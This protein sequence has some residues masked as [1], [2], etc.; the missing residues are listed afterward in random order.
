MNAIGMRPVTRSLEGWARSR[1]YGP[2]GEHRP[3]MMGWTEEQLHASVAALRPW[4]TATTKNMSGRMEV[5]VASVA[6]DIVVD[7]L[8][9]GRG[10]RY[11]RAKSPY[12]LPG[13]Y[14]S[15]DPLF[16]WHFVTRAIDALC[17][18]GLIIHERGT[19]R[20]NCAGQQSVAKSTA[21][22]TALLRP[23]INVLEP[24]GV[25][26]PDEVIV[27]RDRSDKQPI[28]YDD[29][30]KTRKM[31]DEVHRIN[32]ALG[33][34]EVRHHGHKVVISKGRRIFSGS[35]DLGGRFYLVGRSIQGMSSRT[36][37]ELTFVV[38][39]ASHPAVEVDYHT[40]HPVLAYKQSGG[41]APRGDLYAI[42]GFDRKLVKLALNIL[43]NAKTRKSAKLALLGE[44]RADDSREKVG[45]GS[46]AFD[47]DLE[48]VDRVLD[49]VVRKHP[50]L[51]TAFGSD[52]GA[53]LQRI[54]SDMAMTVL[55]RM[56]E[57]TGRCPIPIHDSFVV[58]EPDVFV[59]R[60]TMREVAHERGLRLKLR[61][62]KAV[63]TT[64]DDLRAHKSP[65]VSSRVPSVYNG[66]AD[67]ADTCCTPQSPPPLEVTTPCL[68]KQASESPA[69]G[70][71]RFPGEQQ[72]GP[73]RNRQRVPKAL[74]SQQLRSRRWLLG[75][76]NSAHGPPQVGRCRVHRAG[77]ATHERT[78]SPRPFR[79]APSISQK[80]VAVESGK[81]ESVHGL[82]HPR[83]LS[84]LSSIRKVETRDD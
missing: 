20:R 9:G 81:Y 19:W 29:T 31:R 37:A 56:I 23:L 18:A 79:V 11:Y 22:L 48:F 4:L 2:L 46:Q 6:R 28:D 55:T 50:G 15:K 70:R 10:V 21:E 1:P 76:G 13:R 52:L 84:R 36:R 83:D 54:D 44:L 7:D 62:S 43:F 80:L 65:L 59:L 72:E 41:T 5:A 64:V 61:E 17:A 60:R 78:A 47:T 69:G 63:R 3:L 40:L 26:G 33:R 73:G 35:F 68:R 58:P 71:P 77:S 24:R 30:P 27:L 39:G 75:T 45:R 53:R 12:S 82:A 38:D 25:P 51:R 32:Q 49:A 8:L 14:R 42:D 16:T 67:W 66:R 34:L 57:R 74:F